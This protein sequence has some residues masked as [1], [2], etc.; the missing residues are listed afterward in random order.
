MHA[1]PRRLSG[2]DHADLRVHTYDWTWAQRQ[3]RRADRAGAN[4]PGEQAQL[5]AR[6][7]WTILV[8]HSCIM[9]SKNLAGKPI[10]RCSWAD[11]TPLEIIYHD[12]EWG[13]PQRDD[14]ALFEFLI[15]E[16]AQAGLSWST[17]LAKREGYR[18]AFD[19]YDVQK[20]ARYTDAKLGKLMLNPA[21][22]RNKLKIASARTNAKAFIKVQ[23]EFG[24]FS[25][26]YWAFANNKPI[27]NHFKTMR[28]V[29]PKT[30]LSDRISKDLLKRGFKFVG[31]TI[32]YAYMQATGMVN[33]H[34]TTCDCYKSLGGKTA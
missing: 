32:I 31:S 3:M 28:D 17:I 14:R 11:R 15:L 33:D 22:V 12:K 5:P 21:I 27:I 18:A 10:V 26:Y 34:L 20:I 6:I 1:C 25:A 16:G 19:N 30:E 29:P 7:A 4:L 23:Q 13:V 9:A 24:S 2:N 8:Y